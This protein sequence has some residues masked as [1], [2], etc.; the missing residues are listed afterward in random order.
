MPVERQAQ[1]DCVARGAALIN[2]VAQSPVE[3]PA[4]FRRRTV[5]VPF[6]FLVFVSAC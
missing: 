5:P 1:P 4:G 3:A 2:S 6:A